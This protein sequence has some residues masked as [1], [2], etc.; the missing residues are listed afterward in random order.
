MGFF[1]DPEVAWEFRSQLIG[2]LGVT[3]RLA[4]VVLLLSV[5]LGTG[6][7]LLRVHGP[8]PVALLLASVVVAVRAVPAVVL[9]VFAFFALPFAGVT[10]EAFAA[11]AGTLTLVQV[12][13][14]SEIVRGALAG[15]P[16]GTVEAA[17][18]SG[19]SRLA[20]L[21]HVV[22]PQALVLALPPFLGSCVQLLHNT[23]IASLVTLGDLVS[24]ALAVQTAT[25]SPAAL[26]AAALLYLA[27]LLPLVRLGRRAERRLAPGR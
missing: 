11:A 27:V 18:A 24:E 6:V 2:G 7:A 8:R 23:T 15:V 17:H 12:V 3:V 20:V 4:L 19:L 25:G 1:L 9:I 5:P 13:Y 10:L 14:V 26:L 21:R 22:L 16:P